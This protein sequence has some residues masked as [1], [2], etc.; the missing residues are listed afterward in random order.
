MISAGLPPDMR[1]A[2]AAFVAAAQAEIAAGDLS[3]FDALRTYVGSAQD[4]YMASIA[5]VYGG[6]LVEQCGAPTTLAGNLA[7]R[8]IH[9]APLATEFLN[10][11]G[12]FEQAPDAFRAFHGMHFLILALMTTLSRDRAERIRARFMPGFMASLQAL[13]TADP[14]EKLPA[15]SYL[16]R[17]MY[18]YDGELDVVIPEKNL[19]FRL[20]LDG[21]QNCFHLFGLFQ[22]WMPDI[23]EHIGIRNYPATDPHLLQLMQSEEITGEFPIA[24][25]TLHAYSDFS[26]WQAAAQGALKLEGFVP[27]EQLVWSLPELDERRIL[28]VGIQPVFG[29]RTWH[30]AIH[31]PLH[32][33]LRS[34]VTFVRWLDQAEYAEL[35]E[36]ALTPRA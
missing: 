28:V 17:L 19:G 7:L 21:V 24:I 18:S 27:G 34:G 36:K 31:A 33:A 12:S 20:R 10:R 3:G 13:H 29:S 26:G 25:E 35:A 11:E 23:A 4:P 9:N 15:L 2:M 32:D 5:A 1:K 22:A 30:P 6:T 14:L 8:F 16:H